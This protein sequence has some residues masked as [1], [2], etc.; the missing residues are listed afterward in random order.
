MTILLYIFLSLLLLYAA[1]LLILAL[2]YM[3]TK[4]FKAK[5]KTLQMPLSII[6]CARNEEKN[7]T[8][9]LRSILKQD[10]V[11]RKVQL[12]LI[13]DASTDETV[14]RAESILKGSDLNYKIITNPEHIGKKQSIITAMQQVSNAVVVLHDADTFTISPKWLQ[15]I[16]DLYQ[17]SQPDMIIAPI[18]IANNTGLLWALQAI[19]TKVLALFAAG[20]AFY[21]LPFLCNGANLIFTKAIFEKTG[22]FQSH[23]NVASGDDILFLEAVKKIPD[24]KILYL[25]SKDALVYTYPAF[26]FSQLLNQKVR[27]ASKF[28]PNTNVLNR[29]L[30]LLS[31]L[32][33]AGWLFCFV[34][35]YL[36]AQH[37]NAALFF[38]FFKLSID[39]LLLF[40]ASGF[41][42]NK[43]LLWYSL[44]VGCIY[45]VYACMV[46]LASLF[47]KPNWKK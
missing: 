24:A 33:N 17:Q 43:R 44:P 2:G 40:L 27:W 16:S 28:K 45:P 10:Y 7:I 6:I 1:L 42:K 39:I 14:L 15:S 26:S 8:L 38:I 13:N 25:K 12:I 23:L 11:L 19:E 47:L 37:L 41:I 22:S 20:S 29:A 9:C 36:S 3:F 30:A 5:D 18:G 35:A 46:A 21:K 34:L 31:F 32:V 4:W